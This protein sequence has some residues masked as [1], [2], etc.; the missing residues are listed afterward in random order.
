MNSYYG[1]VLEPGFLFCS[2][3]KYT[4]EQRLEKN[5]DMDV[6]KGVYLDA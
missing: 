3:Y 4:A 6:K 2:G 1:D 5:E